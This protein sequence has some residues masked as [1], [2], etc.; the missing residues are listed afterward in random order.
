MNAERVCYVDSSAI[1]KLVVR[2]MRIPVIPITDTG[3][4]PITNARSS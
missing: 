4:K 2:E 1:V 3:V